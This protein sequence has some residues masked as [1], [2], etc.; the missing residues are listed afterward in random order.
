[1]RITAFNGSPKA[2]R[3]NTHAMVSEFLKGAED[4][5][6]EVENTFLAGKEIKPCIGCY[7][8]WIATPGKCIYDDDMV[9][10]LDKFMASDAVVFASPV[11][12]DNVTGLMKVFMDRLMAFGDP[13]ME[14][15][16]HGECR[17]VKKHDKPAKFIAIS[18]CGFPEQ[19][20]FQVLRL[21][22]RRMA[23]NFGC[24][25]IAEIYRSGGGLLTSTVPD[26]RTAVQTYLAMVRKAGREVVENGSLS[27]ETTRALEQPLIPLLADIDRCIERANKMWDARLAEGAA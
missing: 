4:A 12:A 7:A 2:E 5:G 8:C 11:Y 21:L 25:L 1:M 16:N 6:A 18:N 14:K 13:H 10:L 19:S 26:V 20:H 24:D 22:Y 23:R 9:V 3:S 27:G 15:D 17:H